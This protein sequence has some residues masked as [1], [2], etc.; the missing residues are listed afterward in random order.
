MKKR[1]TKRVNKKSIISLDNLYKRF[2]NL[3][4][5][6]SKKHKLSIQ[7]IADIKDLLFYKNEEG[8]NILLYVTKE[9]NYKL[10]EKIG[11]FFNFLIKKSIFT[12]DEK[13][14]YFNSVDKI[15]RNALHLI[16]RYHKKPLNMYT[17]KL[18]LLNGCNLFHKDRNNK[19]FF[20]HF[21]QNKYF[22]NFFA[23]VL[24]KTLSDTPINNPE[25]LAGFAASLQIF[26]FKLTDALNSSSNGIYYNKHNVISAFY[27]ANM[28]LNNK[29]ITLM[30]IAIMAAY[31]ESLNF[32]HE[33]DYR[34]HNKNY[35]SIIYFLCKSF[36]IE[37]FLKN[38][39]YA[40]KRF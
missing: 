35:L 34:I 4:A 18:L 37:T 12:V 40:K 19:N 13:N 28:E 6:Y 36:L 16:A 5:K 22:D 23:K 1:Q 2:P 7:Q 30:H 10:I 21:I 17:Y 11:R 15:G 32:F 9:N 31:L 33:V 25:K 27:A 14:A 20:Q 29:S 3:L 24:H 39:K 8:C 38:D 26:I